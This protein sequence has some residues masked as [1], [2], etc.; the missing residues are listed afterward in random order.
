[1]IKRIKQSS[2]LFVFI[3]TL[4]LSIPQSTFA[5][6]ISGWL[7]YWAKTEGIASAQKNISTLD[8]VYPFVYNLSSNGTLKDLAKMDSKDWK[9][10]T[11]Y[12]QQ[13]NV[14]VIPTIMTADGTMVHNLLSSSRKRKK[15]VSNIVKTVKKHNFDG[16]DIDYESKRAQ[17]RN[18]FSSFLKD[19][20]KGLKDKMLTCTVEARTP[21][22]SLYHNPPRDIPRAND[23]KEM[24]RH[25][26]QIEIMAYDQQRA[27]I[28]L[29]NIRKGAPYMP[30]ADVDWVEKVIQE[31][32]KEIPADKIVL[33]VPTYGTI[34]EV[35]VAPEWFKTYT[36]LRAINQPDGIAL[37]LDK[38]ITPL[39]NSAGEMGFAY[40]AEDIS[41]E[42]KTYQAPESY[43]ESYKAAGQALAYATATGNTTT[44][45]I[46]SWSDAKAIEQ[47]VNLAKKYNL[48]GVSLFKIDGQE[49]QEVWDILKDVQ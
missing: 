19:L 37:A 20:D 48:K 4:L 9:Q 1:M 35:T 26:D 43:P 8:I 42:V 5:F 34:Y 30:N 7:P 29:N 21:L 47:K 10:F 40:F 44:V 31:T 16:I 33:G 45:R 11:S 14:K 15:H 25:C 13:Q 28:L 12:A 2:L 24:A 41:D 17:T 49:D 36:R 3:L 23:Y 46:A 22:S 18:H 38:N 32:L 6:E 39:R 27:D